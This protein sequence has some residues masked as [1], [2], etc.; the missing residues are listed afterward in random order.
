[1]DTLPLRDTRLKILGFLNGYTT[2]HGFSPTLAE[3][4]EA[5]G[6]PTALSRISYHLRILESFGLITQERFNNTKGR[7]YVGR[8][9]ITQQG[10]STLLNVKQPRRHRARV[11]NRRVRQ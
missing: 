5:I 10:L 4:G 11:V 8:T 2:Q 7:V 9:K 3:I 6:N 1:M